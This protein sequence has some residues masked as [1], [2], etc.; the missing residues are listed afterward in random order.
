MKKR[1]LL[2]ILFLGFGL[3]LVSIT[4][5]QGK[6]IFQEDFT[7]LPDKYS[8]QKINHEDFTLK[9]DSY[10]LSGYKYNTFLSIYVRFNE[11]TFG[12]RIR[13]LDVEDVEKRREYIIRDGGL[14]CTLRILDYS[15][16]VERSET[17]GITDVDKDF[18]RALIR[19]TV[20]STY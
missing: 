3:L 2:L 15:V 10:D 19:I 5:A 12:S 8:E 6:V 11:K 14:K 9:V 18:K 20:E 16:H 4:N 17:F 13:G 1:R 7:L